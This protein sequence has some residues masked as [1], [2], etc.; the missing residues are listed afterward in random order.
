M[1][2]GDEEGRMNTANLLVLNSTIT[3]YSNLLTDVDVARTVAF[4]A[5]EIHGWKLERYLEAGYTRHD[6]REVFRDVRVTGIGWVADVERQGRGQKDL[7]K[8]AAH[9]FALAETVG[10]GGVQIL[11][12]PVD[13]QEVIDFHEGRSGGKYFDLLGL[14]QEELL[15]RAARNVAMLADVAREVG[16]ILYLEPLAWSPINGLKTSLRLID[17]VERDNVKLVIDYWHCFTSGVTPDEVA[18]LDKNQIYGVHV[19]DSLPFEGGIPLEVT[20]RDVPTGQGVLDLA[21]WTDAV[22]ATGYSGWWSGE[23]FSKRMQQ[24]NPYKIAR[25][26]KQSLEE[27]IR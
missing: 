25:E 13:V 4:D 26:V 11:S 15:D 17:A 24:Q 14:G 9:V 2:K 16:L 21:E 27:L 7:L 12:G 20:N 8:E 23:T 3:R 22:K 5:M 1:R 6:L 18:K 19:C 10:A